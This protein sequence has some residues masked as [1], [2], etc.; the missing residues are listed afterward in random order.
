[1]NR[2]FTI[3]DIRPYRKTSLA[4]DRYFQTG[5]TSASNLSPEPP[6]MGVGIHIQGSDDAQWAQKKNGKISLVAC[7]LL[8]VIPPFHGGL[9]CDPAP[10]TKHPQTTHDLHPI[11]TPSLTTT[12]FVSG[13]IDVD[14]A[15]FTTH[16][17]PRILAA[18]SSSHSF[19]LG[20]A[21]G[22]DSLALEFLH[23]HTDPERVTVYLTEYENK[24]YRPSL[25]WHEAAGGKI[26]VAG[27]VTNLRDEAM[28]EASG[29]DI[30]RYRPEAEAKELY[31]EM[32]YPRVSATEL[33][34]RRRK[35]RMV[36]D[37]GEG[38]QNG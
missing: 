7:C 11:M 8:E 33:N 22:I 32:W 6:I 24:V 19:V 31:G 25:A 16:Y 23:A 38:K 4:L 1:L 14:I 3:F 36:L 21:P 13:P 30:L 20:P 29:Y 34:E 15:Y 28:T 9:V 27:I 5:L 17:T 10:H 12:A 35:T 18:I 37:S 2:S 26:V